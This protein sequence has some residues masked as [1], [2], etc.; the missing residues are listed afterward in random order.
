M[1]GFEEMNAVWDAWLPE[2]AHRPG[3]P[4]RPSWRRHSS[5]SRSGSSPRSSAVRVAVL[6]AGV[7]GVATAYELWRDGHEVVVLDRAR[8]ARQ[9]HLLRQRRHG[10]PRPRLRLVVAQGAAHAAARPDARRPG[11]ALPVPGRPAVLA[12]VLALLSPVHS[13]ARR[14]QHPP[15]GRLVPL[16]PGAAACRRGRYGGRLWRP[17]GWR[18]LPLPRCRGPGRS[19]GQGADPA[20]RGRRGPRG[21]ARRGGCDR[22]GL[23]AGARPLRRR[24]LRAGRRERRRQAVLAAGW[25]IGWPSAASSSGWADRYPH[26]RRLRPAG[27]RPH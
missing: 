7:I 23:R 5:R 6:G 11:A 2:G 27:H 13:R 24:P 20:R 22:P 19:R 9:R 10:R 18:T 3:P 16:Q 4:S 17:Q 15:Q 1:R 14:R 25:P 8:R 21:D 12:L 26:R